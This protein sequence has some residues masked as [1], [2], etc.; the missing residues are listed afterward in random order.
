M[1]NNISPK[2]VKGSF[3]T[4]TYAVGIKKKNNLNEIVPFLYILLNILL[5]APYFSNAS[6][7]RDN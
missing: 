4:E 6:A 3:S 2:R 5:H 1:G 7:L